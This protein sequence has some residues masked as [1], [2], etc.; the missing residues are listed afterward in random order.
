MGNV[1]HE[2]LSSVQK[3]L[4]A[5]WINTRGPNVQRRGSSKQEIMPRRNGVKVEDER[6]ISRSQYQIEK[7]SVEVQFNSKTLHPTESIDPPVSDAPESLASHASTL[8]SSCLALRKKDYAALW[9]LHC[10]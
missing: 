5:F 4:N 9:I 6:R 1:E 2:V 3:T 10:M 8:L 7:R